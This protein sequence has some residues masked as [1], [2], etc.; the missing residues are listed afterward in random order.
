MI[1]AAAILRSGRQFD[2]LAKE[3]F[4]MKFFF[5]I[6]MLALLALNV[7]AREVSYNG[8]KPA[9]IIDVRTPDEFLAG[10]VDGAI[11]IPV[12]QIGQGIAS[13]KGLNKDSPILIYCRSGRRSAVART[14]L[15]KQGYK[16]VMDGGGID[17]LTKNLKEC[18]ARTC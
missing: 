1:P 8:T 3:I 17:E 15:E 9:A 16:R 11:N 14:V 13:V 5:Q 6:L 7:H 10:H 18:T 4:N 2:P 12:D